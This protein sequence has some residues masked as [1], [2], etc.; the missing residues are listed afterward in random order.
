MEF[1]IT[2]ICK[3]EH[4]Q[5]WQIVH[6]WDVEEDGQADDWQHVAEQET[7][8]ANPGIAVVVTMSQTHSLEENDVLLISEGVI[9]DLG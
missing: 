8:V 4:F 1:K 7:F 9:P 5:T 3:F 2:K 6:L